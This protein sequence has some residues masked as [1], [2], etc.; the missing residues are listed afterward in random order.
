M[1]DSLSNV[2]KNFF[3]QPINAKQAGDTGMAMVLICLLIGLFTHSDL[4]FKIATLL[5]VINMIW[6]TVFRLVARIW[7]GGSILLG[8]VVSKILLT[9]IYFGLVTP[10]GV[11]RRIAGADAMLL[12]Q[13][14]KGS[15]SVFKK[16]NY[17]FQAK[18]IEKPF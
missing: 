1:T 3:K 2:Q 4:L 13:W 16:R 12:K 7:I 5:L 11:V 14:Q 9:V 17:Q 6:P 18:D 15:L 8:T 10:I